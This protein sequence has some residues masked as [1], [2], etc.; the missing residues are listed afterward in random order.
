MGAI[1]LLLVNLVGLVWVG[2]LARRGSM[3]IQWLL[4]LM[5]VQLGSL[6][7]GAGFARGTLGWLWG[8]IVPLIWMSIMLVV[9]VWALTR[10]GRATEVLAFQDWLTEVDSRAQFEQDLEREVERAGRDGRSAT[11]IWLDL[12]SFKGVNDQFGH[13]VGDEVLCQVAA[14]VKAW[15]RDGDYVGRLGGDEYGVLLCQRDPPVPTDA[16]VEELLAEIRRPLRVHD[17]TIMLTAAAGVASAPSDAP[18][19]AGLLVMADLA[20]YRAKALGGNCAQPYAPEMSSEAVVDAE[21]RQNLAV[22]I[23]NCAFDLDYQMVV[24]LATGQPSGAEALVRWVRDGRRINA[25]VFIEYAQKS[26]QILDIGAQVLRQLERDVPEILARASPGFLLH[27]NLSIKELTARDVVKQITT[28]PLVAHAD[29]IVLEV[30][31]TQPSANLGDLEGP[32]ADMTAQGY[33]LAIDDF[34]TGYSN[35]SR[36]ARLQPSIIKIDRSIAMD[37][38]RD[39][40]RPV[41]LLRATVAICAAVDAI[42]VVEGVETPEQAS[43]MR[44]LGITHAQGYLFARPVPRTQFL[45]SLESWP[46]PSS[47][48]TG[49]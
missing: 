40:G 44:S 12:D 39:H 17:N 5:V 21:L 34:G 35:L 16:A 36:L 3:V 49:S 19:A 33:R 1:T 11:L 45:Q 25:S 29:Q 28:G 15:V 30:T 41:R 42:A 7:S 18:D 23:S 8:R 2:W 24:D 9:L 10:I 22:A 38:A 27:V 46:A 4:V 13:S 14:R 31:E 32:L 43:L 6:I 48:P 47:T 26:G 37:A 20:M